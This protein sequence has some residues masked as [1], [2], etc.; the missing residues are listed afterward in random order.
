M[1][2][3]P[4]A[5]TPSFGRLLDLAGAAAYLNDSPRHVRSLWEHRQIAAV[6]IGRKVRFD[7]R[8]LDR[9]IES[10]RVEAIR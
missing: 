5:A 4:T 8:D 6:R 9:Y 7:P 2:E 3:S 1:T 10:Q